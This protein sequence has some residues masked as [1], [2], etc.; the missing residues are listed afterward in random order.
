L[1]VRTTGHDFLHSCRH[2]LGLHCHGEDARVSR[3]SIFVCG[4]V[5]GYLVRVDNG[6]TGELVRH[7]D[8]GFVVTAIAG[9]GCPGGA[10]CEEVEG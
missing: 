10:N 5:V 7:V 9:V 1:P 8:G 6:N 2:F 3:G 4:G